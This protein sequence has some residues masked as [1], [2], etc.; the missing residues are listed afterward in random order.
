L[1]DEDIARR[2]CEKKILRD[3]KKMERKNLLDINKKGGLQ[4]DACGLQLSKP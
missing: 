4:L 3:E 1:R 2:Y